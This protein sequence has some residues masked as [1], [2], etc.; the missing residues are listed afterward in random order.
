MFPPSLDSGWPG[1]CEGIRDIHVCIYIYIYTYIHM[2]I[3]IYT[4]MYTYMYMIYIHRYIYI[5]IYTY[6]H[7]LP[8]RPGAAVPRP[9]PP[10]RLPHV[11][12]HA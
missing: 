4:Y 7:I 10:H 1:S 2:Y 3:C 5:Y 12:G 8:V 11:E 6:I 9:L